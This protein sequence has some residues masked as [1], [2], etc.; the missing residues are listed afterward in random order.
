MANE[1]INFPNANSRNLY[2]MSKSEL[3]SRLDPRG[4]IADIAEILT[5]S[6]EILL[7]M[8]FKESNLLEGM[9]VTL[10]TGLPKAYWKQIN[11]GVPP[12]KSST[13]QVVEASGI[14]ES[15]SKTDADLVEMNGNTKEFRLSEDKPHIEAM[16]QMMSSSLIYGDATDS[17]EGFNG[18]ECRYNT[19]NESVLS[20]KNVVDAGG[21]G[22]KLTSVYIVAWGDNVFGFYP[23]GSTAGLQV[24]DKGKILTEDEDGFY[25]DA[26]VS[27]Y[28]W[29]MGLCVKDWRYC[30]RVCNINV[31][32]LRNGR[33]IG[34]ADVKG[35]GTTNLILKI[36]E[37]L[38]KIPTQGRNR[39]AIYMNNDVMSALNVLSARQNSN[40][41]TL[42]SGM[43]KYGERETWKTFAGIPLRRCDAILNAEKKVTA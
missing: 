31:N 12:S 39:F 19:L 32:D 14:M 20:S 24:E 9:Q 28:R 23:K 1:N 10:R 34:T 3:V 27:K 22:D 7:D 26:Y 16:N 36:Q 4:K 33:G 30:A 6:N 5:Q 38:D 42:E 35:A 18:L 21:A 11:R 37:A 29:A 17:K 43:N 25:F 8:E 40:V 2:M 15:W 13:A 41:I